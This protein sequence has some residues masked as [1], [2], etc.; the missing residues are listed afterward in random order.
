MDLF[1]GPLWDKTVTHWGPSK[2]LDA[3]YSDIKNT[4]LNKHKSKYCYMNLLLGPLWDKAVT[5]T[6][7]LPTFWNVTW[8]C[9]DQMN[10]SRHTMVTSRLDLNWL[11]LST[12]WV[13]RRPFQLDPAVPLRF[14]QQVS[15]AWNFKMYICLNSSSFDLKICFLNQS[16]WLCDWQ[17]ILPGTI[18]TELC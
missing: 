8:L 14:C 2:P 17:D 11:K 16:Y 7:V 1:E 18:R 3:R 13:D 4:Y 5:H 12:V 15:I 6:G 10:L 9:W